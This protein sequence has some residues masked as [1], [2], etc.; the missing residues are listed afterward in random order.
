MIEWGF[1]TFHSKIR[2][3]MA[4]SGLHENLK[5]GLFTKCAAITTKLE[6]IMV[7]PQEENYAYEKFYSKIKD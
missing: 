4:H 5:N 3:M 1:A 6:N 2:A 7:N